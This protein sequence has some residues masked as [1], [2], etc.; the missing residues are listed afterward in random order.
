MD[1]FLQLHF[2]SRGMMRLA[3]LMAKY[4]PFNIVESII[5]MMS[6]L[7]Y[8]DFS[9]YGIQRPKEGPFTMFRKYKKYP[10]IDVGTHRKIKSGEIQVCCFVSIIINSVILLVS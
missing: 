5:V 10:L 9:K 7:W 3:P 1:E 8:G 4:I 2:L 6:K